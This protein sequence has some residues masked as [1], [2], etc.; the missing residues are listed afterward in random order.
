M[1]PQIIYICM[2]FTALIMSGY[3]HGKEKKGTHNLFVDLV[4][5]AISV[6]ILIWGGFFD[7]LFK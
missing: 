1:I 2:F 4:T 7:S 6:G 5:I 3:N